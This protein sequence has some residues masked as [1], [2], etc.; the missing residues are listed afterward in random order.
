MFS[1]QEFHLWTLSLFKLRIPLIFNLKRCLSYMRYCSRDFF[2]Y[3]IFCFA[4]LFNLCFLPP[5][6]SGRDLRGSVVR[7]VRSAHLHPA[8]RLLGG[9]GSQ[10]DLR[11]VIHAGEQA[12][13]VTNTKVQAETDTRANNRKQT[14]THARAEIIYT[15]HGSK[16]FLL[17]CLFWLESDPRNPIPLNPMSY[18]CCACLVYV[19]RYTEL[20]SLYNRVDLGSIGLVFV[21]LC[22]FLLNCF[23]F[24]WTVFACV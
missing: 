6:L 17:I 5:T 21:E 18:C 22:W 2:I 15:P 14:R 4:C 3:I 16:T 10:L 20:V 23:V 11:S 8:R 13:T 19:Q 7:H 12:D 9:C 1:C 24:C